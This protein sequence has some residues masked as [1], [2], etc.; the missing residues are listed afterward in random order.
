M[1]KV[2]DSKFIQATIIAFA[3][4][5]LFVTIKPFILSVS[6]ID[7]FSI[8]NLN[9]LAS[10]INQL[11]TNTVPAV[12]NGSTVTVN[13]GNT[14]KKIENVLID[15][16]YTQVYSDS[17]RAY[18]AIKTYPISISN[19][20]KVDVVFPDSIYLAYTLTTTTLTLSTTSVYTN[21]SN[22]YSQNYYSYFC[23]IGNYS[24]ESN[25]PQAITI[26]LIEYN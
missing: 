9:K 15:C 1:K 21:G 23:G 16:R 5:G 24:T 4:I 14:I 8:F 22:S 6:N 17:S 26:Q 18:S 3:V 25:L 13:G 12:T 19:S 2:F 7:D 10:S 11:A 20:D